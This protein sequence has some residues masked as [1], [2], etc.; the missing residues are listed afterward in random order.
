MSLHQ[1]A[2]PLVVPPGL[3]VL[4]FVEYLPKTPA[5]EDHKIGCREVALL[6]LLLE[7]AVKCGYCISYSYSIFIFDYINFLRDELAMHPYGG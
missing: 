6:G 1:G 2:G 4:Y 7:F 3:V 5:I